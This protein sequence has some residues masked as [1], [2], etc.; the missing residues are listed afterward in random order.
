MAKRLFV[1]ARLETPGKPPAAVPGVLRQRGDDGAA[2]FNAKSPSLV[3]GE[4]RDDMDLKALDKSEAPEYSRVS[5]KTTDGEDVYAYEY[6]K[7]DFSTLPLIKD[8]RFRR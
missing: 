8:G 1:Y 3:Y 6:M 5:V 2:R 4:L 7:N